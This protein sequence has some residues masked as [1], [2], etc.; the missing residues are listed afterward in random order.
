[1]SYDPY[2]VHIHEMNLITF[3]IVDSMEGDS[4]R[5]KYG[6]VFPGVVRPILNWEKI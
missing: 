5:G 6:G 4:A 2:I 1:M 3:S